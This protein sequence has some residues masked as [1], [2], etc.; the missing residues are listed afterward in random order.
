MLFLFPFKSDELGASKPASKVKEKTK[1]IYQVQTAQPGSSSPTKTREGTLDVS[2]QPSIKGIVIS[3]SRDCILHPD[4]YAKEEITPALSA[5]P[6][7]IDSIERPMDGLTQ[8]EAP[9][10]NQKTLRIWIKQRLI[11]R[12]FDREDNALVLERETKWF[13]QSIGIKYK[14]QE[15]RS[16]SQVKLGPFLFEWN[17]KN[18]NSNFL[19]MLPSNQ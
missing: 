11:E 13:N 2:V 15:D 4:G 10:N 5:I 8:I 9:K 3:S 14:R 16:I 7:S 18:K 19:S 17:K 12:I 1:K 6:V